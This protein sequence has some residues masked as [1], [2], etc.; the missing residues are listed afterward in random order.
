[1][2]VTLM[3]R[4]ERRYCLISTSNLAGLFDNFI[5]LHVSQN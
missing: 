4:I 1:M 2:N 3:S 5:L